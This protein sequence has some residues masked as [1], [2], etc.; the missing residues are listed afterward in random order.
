MKTYVN[1]NLLGIKRGEGYNHSISVSVNEM[2]K[3]FVKNLLGIHQ[4]S[5]LCSTT[6]DV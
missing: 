4:V 1:L 3:R 6:L 5:Q 2:K